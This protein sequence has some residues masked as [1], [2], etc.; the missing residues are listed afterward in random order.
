MASLLLMAILFGYPMDGARWTKYTENP[1]Y[2]KTVQEE[3]NKKLSR[4]E[5]KLEKIHQILEKIEE[6]LQDNSLNN[7]SPN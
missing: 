6:K 2:N 1:P 7:W 4:L 3:M 5:Y